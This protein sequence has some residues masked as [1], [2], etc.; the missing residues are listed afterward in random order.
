MP[1][2]MV[3]RTAEY[4]VEIEAETAEDAYAEA[5]ELEDPDDFDAVDWH[6]PSVEG[7]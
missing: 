6:Q 2:W 7:A 3:T 4:T 1:A 5:Q